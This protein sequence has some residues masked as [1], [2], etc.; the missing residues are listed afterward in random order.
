MA[1]RKKDAP[2]SKANLTATGYVW[3]CPYCKA[4]NKSKTL[5]QTYKCPKCKDTAIVGDVSHNHA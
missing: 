3:E 2:P 1:K 4:V 5:T